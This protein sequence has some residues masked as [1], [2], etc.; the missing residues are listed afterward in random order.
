MFTQFK[1]LIEDL[2]RWKPVSFED[3]LYTLCEQGLWATIFYRLN[4]SLFLINIPII[5][6]FIRIINFIIFKFSEIALGIS[7]SPGASIGPGFYIG[8]TGVIVIHPD[9]KAG[10]KLSLGQLVTIGTRGVG[11]TGAPTIGDNVYIGVGAKILGNIKIGSDVKI[12]ANA[13]VI[14][15]IPDN[16]TAVG[17]PAKVVKRN[18]LKIDKGL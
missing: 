11:Y 14:S 9:V 10:K 3:A 8:H 1:F 5:K 6:I 12:G 16:T 18:D 2:K 15:D 13:V 4:R 7:L 17:I